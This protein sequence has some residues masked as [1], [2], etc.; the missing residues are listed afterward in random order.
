MANESTEMANCHF[1]NEKSDTVAFTDYDAMPRSQATMNW[2]LSSPSLQQREP[3]RSLPPYGNSITEH[4]GSRRLLMMAR[5]E[6]AKQQA[7]VVFETATAGAP[8]FRAHKL[9]LISNFALE[10]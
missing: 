5:K 6:Q 4:R 7:S 2:S 8:K 3:M 10:N 9:A 1:Y